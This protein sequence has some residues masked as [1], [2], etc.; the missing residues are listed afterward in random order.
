MP[1]KI[2]ITKWL[3]A[4]CTEVYDEKLTCIL[5]ERSVHKEERKRCVHSKL[6]VAGCNIFFLQCRCDVGE[7]GGTGGE[8]NEQQGECA[9]NW[10]EVH[11]THFQLATKRHLQLTSRD[12]APSAPSSS[13]S[14][15]TGGVT[16]T[17]DADI[18]KELKERL[19]K[20]EDIIQRW[21]QGRIWKASGTNFKLYNM[22][23]KVFLETIFYKNKFIF[24]LSFFLFESK[25]GVSFK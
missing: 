25:L 18:I 12:D 13:S 23:L 19:S 16:A 5:H 14:G 17:N 9:L 3:C 24:L 2:I 1:Q 4:Y 6:F 22:L 7:T 8:W 11:D 20:M 15:T 21:A 10:R